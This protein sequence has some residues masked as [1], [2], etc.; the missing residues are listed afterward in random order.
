MKLLP[1]MVREQPR[2][3]PV[4]SLMCG[5]PS[6]TIGVGLTV[7]LVSYLLHRPIGSPSLYEI[8][9]YR[10]YPSSEQN[11]VSLVVP[12]GDFLVMLAGG[13]WCGGIGIY[14]ARRRHPGRSA[15]TSIGG[16]ITCATALVVAWFLIVRA[17]TW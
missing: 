4:I 8:K 7:L 2:G 10:L 17:A 14:L 16:M 15:T 3:E 11:L 1:L 9:W 13:A 5:V 12:S 6:L